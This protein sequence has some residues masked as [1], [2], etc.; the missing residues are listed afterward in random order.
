MA[1]AAFAVIV[2]GSRSPT[3][4][5]TAWGIIYNEC[6]NTQ[7]LLI[8][9]NIGDPPRALKAEEFL[10]KFYIP[11]IAGLRCRHPDVLLPPTIKPEEP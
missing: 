4:R 3:N 6:F 10:L 7:P 9:L 11:H 5:A 2:F 8:E 1:P